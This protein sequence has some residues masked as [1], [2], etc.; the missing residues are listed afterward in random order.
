MTTVRPRTPVSP[1]PAT[2][3]QLLAAADLGTAAA[4][5]DLS[6]SAPAARQAYAAWRALR[7]HTGRD[8]RRMLRVAFDTG[9]GRGVHAGS[10]S[11]L[12]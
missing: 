3:A 6:G 12:G 5:A 8:A 10:A 1:R 4:T 9:Y 2:R 7:R 11:L